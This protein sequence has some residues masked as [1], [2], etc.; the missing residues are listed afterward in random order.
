MNYHFPRIKQKMLV[1]EEKVILI[2]KGMNE[3]M[4]GGG[5]KEMNEKTSFSLS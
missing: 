3:K 5:K 4:E 1:L 2:K